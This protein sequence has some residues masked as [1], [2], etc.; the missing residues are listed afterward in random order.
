MVSRVI[1]STDCVCDLPQ[2]LV[3][4]YSI[5]I[6]CYYMQVGSARFQDI[7]EINSDSI[8]EYM[9]QDD[10]MLATMSASVEEYGKFFQEISG[11]GK[12][13]VI[14][15]SVAKHISN[16][17]RNAMEAAK[18]FPCV[19][20]VDS[21]KV[22]G[23]MG[24][25]VLVAADL[26]KKGATKDI[27]LQKLESVRERINCSFVVRS[28]KFLMYNRRM[29]GIGVN[30]LEALS[31]HPMVTLHNSAFTHSGFCFGNEYQYARSYINKRLSNVNKIS[32]EVLFI[33]IAGCDY[34]LQQFIVTEVRKKVEWKHIYVVKASAT[35]SCNSGPGTFSLAYFNK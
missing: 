18:N 13:S 34:D 23:G 17:Y 11:N 24:L 29:R 25:F 30:R 10:T 7:T 14:H 27:I 26:A 33:V 9:A 5:P 21:G 4:K 19:Q 20:V 1:I 8:L 16:G 28:L 32:D 15:I 12:H 31:L 35:I 2:N 6:M 3:D 22:S